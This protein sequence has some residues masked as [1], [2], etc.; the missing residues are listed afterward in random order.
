MRNKLIFMLLLLLFPL[1]CKALEC[2][3]A[4]Q[5]RLRKL[6]S[7]IQ[8]SYEYVESDGRIT[9]NV[10]LSNM[11]NDLYIEDGSGTYYYNGSSDITLNG[12]NP[13]TN[14]KYKIHAN[15]DCIK[16]YLTIKY[17][18]LPYFNK[19][20][21]D[22]LCEGK[23]YALCNKWTKVS[24]EYDEF[25]KKIKEFDNNTKSDNNEEKLENTDILDF[26]VSF[27]YENY[28][29]I[30]GGFALIFIIAELI[31]RKKEGLDW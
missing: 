16:N 5:A 17:V 24:Y 26:I 11:T 12:Y 28:L 8:T 25:A 6:A 7:N 18:N 10:T 27:V 30:G 22:P 19:Y 21:N 3:Y 29:Y 2:T 31:K 23:N 4:E 20:Y 1:S 9:F 14:I 15:N 13:G